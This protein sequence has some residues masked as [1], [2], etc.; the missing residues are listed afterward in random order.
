[1]RAV[2]LVEGGETFSAGGVESGVIE[3]GALIVLRELGGSARRSFP[4]LEAGSIER[5][6]FVERGEINI[7]FAILE[8]AAGDGLLLADT[9]GPKESAVRIERIDVALEAGEDEGA[10]AS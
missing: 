2:G 3:G 10:V 1:M 7:A 4:S 8:E 6:N 5:E 9:I